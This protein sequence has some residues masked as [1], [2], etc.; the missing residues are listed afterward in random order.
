MRS[1]PPAD[2]TQIPI[3]H[4]TM[5]TFTVRQAVFADLP[6]LAGLFD[7]YRQFQGQPSDRSACLAF[8]RDRFEHGQ[9]VVFLAA[10]Q[11]SLR[12][13]AQLYPSFSSTALA[14]VF[15]LNDLFVAQSGR[16]QGVAS[17]LL[18]AVQAYAWSLG[19]CRV[20]LNVARSNRSAQQLY[21][22]RAWVGDSQFQMYHCHRPSS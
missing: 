13:F 7:D 8:L 15:I 9:S 17:A 3:P 1:E 11:N 14:R 5:H 18:E 10:V 20:S 21:E 22:S 12:G 4:A 19:A 2:P 16:R 6:D